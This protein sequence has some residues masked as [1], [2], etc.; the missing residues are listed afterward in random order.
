MCGQADGYDAI[1]QRIGCALRDPE[2]CAVVLDADSPGGDVAG[3]EQC[4]ARIQNERAR[5]GK[6]IIGYVNER[7]A[8]ACYWL[9]CGVCDEIYLPPS[10]RAGSVGAIAIHASEA[11]KLKREGVDVYLS[12]Q[13]DGKMRPS[14]VE[15]LDEIGKA[16]LDAMTKEGCDRF[17]AFVSARRGIPIEA[18]AAM[19]AD[20]FT[21]SKAVAVGLCDGISS[22]EDVVSYAAVM[23]DLHTRDQ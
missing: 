23:A 19:N 8:S 13:P 6:P 17:W 9:M 10:G 22:F 3:L 14:P 15:P 2:S 12:R 5:A 21:G 7:A 11:R 16:R 1:A 18:V 20:M 4:I